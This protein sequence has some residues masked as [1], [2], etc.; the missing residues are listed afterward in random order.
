[1]FTEVLQMRAVFYRAQCGAGED[2]G[3]DILSFRKSK[4][5][6]F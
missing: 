1:M 2:G 5:F 3:K 6:L 4:V